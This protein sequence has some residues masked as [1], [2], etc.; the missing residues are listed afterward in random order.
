MTKGSRACEDTREESCIHRREEPTEYLTVDLR[1]EH[2]VRKD[3]WL[4]SLISIQ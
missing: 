1:W 4:L 3:G 2:L